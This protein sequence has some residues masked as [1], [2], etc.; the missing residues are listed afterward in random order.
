[1]KF[2]AAKRFFTLRVGN[3]ATPAKSRKFFCPPFTHSFHQSQVAVAHE[4]QKWCALAIL[5]AHEEQRNIRSEQNHAGSKL[6]LFERRRLS[7]AIAEQAIA[8]LIVILR[9]HN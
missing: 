5:L 3:F 7:Q 4:I 1:M 6:Q 9:K 8:D 2:R